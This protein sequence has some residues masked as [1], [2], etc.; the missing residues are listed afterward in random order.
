M[1]LVAGVMSGESARVV[2]AGERLQAVALLLVG[3]RSRRA[4]MRAMCGLEL[5]LELGVDGVD[6]RGVVEAEGNTALVDTTMTPRRPARLRRAM[7]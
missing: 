3:G 7:A 5:A 4:S 6:G 1:R 2:E